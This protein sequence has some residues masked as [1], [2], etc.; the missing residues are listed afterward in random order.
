MRRARSCVRLL[1]R[2][3]PAPCC[4]RCRAA[5]SLILPAPTRK[6]VRPCSEPKILRASSTATE[7]METEFEPIPSPS[8]PF[9]P[10][11]RRSAADAPVGPPPCP[12]RAPRQRPLSPGPESAARPPPSS[13]GSRPRGTDAAPP[14]GRAA[15]RCAAQAAQGP[16]RSA[17]CRKPVRSA[18]RPL[19]SGQHL[20]PV[21]GGDDHA[22]GHARHRGQ[23]ARRLRQSSRQM[24]IRSRSSM[25]AVLWLTPMSAS[26]IAHRTCAHG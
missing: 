21:A 6:T 3:A 11:Q 10:R 7:A 22:L 23:R 26:V 14:P 1:T 15:R 25:G 18:F 19:D 5:S 16:G 24:A 8:A 17:R 4:T 20:H 12:Q 9:W 2:I 13:P